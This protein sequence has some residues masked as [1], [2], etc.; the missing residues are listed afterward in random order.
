MSRLE[1]GRRYRRVYCLTLGICYDDA[2]LGLRPPRGGLEKEG[3]NRG[4]D[5]GR[6]REKRVLLLHGENFYCFCVETL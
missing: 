3:R 1:A 4:G 2:V 6:R 5:G